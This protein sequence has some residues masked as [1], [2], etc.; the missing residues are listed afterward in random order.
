MAT[1][2][3]LPLM[4][5]GEDEGGFLKLFTVH[6]IFRIKIRMGLKFYPIFIH[7]FLENKSLGRLFDKIK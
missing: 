3:L 4:G 2:V 1:T 5:E 7:G 6:G